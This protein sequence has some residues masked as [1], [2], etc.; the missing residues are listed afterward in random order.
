MKAMKKRKIVSII[1]VLAVLLSWGVFFG[2]ATE[3][4]EE[5]QQRKIHERLY[6]ELETMEDDEKV[7][8]VIW[9]TDI[10]VKAVEKKALE[11]AG[12]D[13]KQLLPQISELNFT[14]N[15]WRTSAK[16]QSRELTEE[17]KQYVLSIAEST[18]ENRKKQTKEIHKYLYAKRDL[19]AEES[20]AKNMAFQKERFKKNE[21]LYIGQY[22]PMLVAKLSKKTILS[23][24]ENPN[25]SMVL[26]Y[27]ES[28]V[29]SAES[30]GV[31]VSNISAN[32]TRDTLGYNGEDIIIGQIEAEAAGADHW[33]RVRDIM[34]GPDGMVPQATVHR[35]L[36]DD[37]I[38]IYSAVDD[39]I[40]LGVD[41]INMSA[42]IYNNGVYDDLCVFV[43]YVV[44]T[45]GITFVVSAGNN[46]EESQW[47]EEIGTIAS[48][49]MANNAITVGAIDP[50]GTVTTIDDELC[51]YSSYIEG[52]YQVEKPDVVAPTV[53]VNGGT[54]FSAP[55]VAGLAAQ[56]MDK[57]PALIGNALKVKA[58]I[59][60]GCNRK[61][62]ENM[63]SLTEKEG[64]GVVNAVTSMTYSNNWSVSGSINYNTTT[65]SYSKYLKAN[66]PAT[67]VLVWNR[68]ALRSGTYVH[69]YPHTDWDL[70]VI[71]SGCNVTYNSVTPYNNVEYIRF[72]PPVSGNYVIE[73]KLYGET[74]TN[75]Q[76]AI[77]VNQF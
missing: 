61:T 15:M 58:I 53:G 12:V 32:Y 67:I 52:N 4:A 37:P 34:V 16:T 47:G 74:D 24:E 18:E 25:V 30:I 3:V 60:A 9:L 64:A 50:K 48:P 20:S 39:L 41:I 69:S 57:E 54:S 40:A 63:G 6:E 23:F 11:K 38:D 46:G 21:V 76:Y 44:A 68:N 1:L 55:Y 26:L 62:T 70:K 17:G 75:T 13:P 77:A 66:T 27:E 5:L 35:E 33:Q 29:V 2:D 28:Q 51:A 73:I 43:D 59:M 36:V 7:S 45:F 71:G 19:V 65:R 42:G 31:G 14:N 10:D 49:G 8:V 72:I 22:S 56:L